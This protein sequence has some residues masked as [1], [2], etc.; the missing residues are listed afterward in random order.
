MPSRISV[1]APA[2]LALAATS[3]ALGDA[4]VTAVYAVEA[5]ALWEAVEFHAPS[6]AIMPPIASSRREGEGLGATKV[7]T[8]QGGGEVLLQL[9]YYAPDA[10]AFNYVIRTSPLPVANYVGEVRV[11]DLG[12]GR[13][14][15]SWRGVFEPAGATAEAADAALQGFYE[16]IAARLGEMFPRED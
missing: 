11:T 16:A 5:D 12:D 13:A 10:R 14:E 8:L 7:N 15:L 3:P 9:V 4:G 2:A 6:E 1:V